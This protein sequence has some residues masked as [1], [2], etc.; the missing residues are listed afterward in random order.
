[1]TLKMNLEAKGIVE[2]FW[3]MYECEDVSALLKLTKQDVEDELKDRGYVFTKLAVK[4][5][6]ARLQKIGR[7]EARWP[8]NAWNA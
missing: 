3:D 8:K 7:G 5:A 4:Q 1:M 2:C 6:F